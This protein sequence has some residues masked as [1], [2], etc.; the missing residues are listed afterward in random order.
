[1]NLSQNEALIGYYLGEPVELLGDY[2]DGW[3]GARFVNDRKQKVWRMWA[4]QVKPEPWGGT[5]GPV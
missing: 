2:N 5:R 1:M 3:V 4:D